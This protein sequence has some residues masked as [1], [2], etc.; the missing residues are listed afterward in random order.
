[1]AD[2]VRKLFIDA[3]ERQL[4]KTRRRSGIEFRCNIFRR[5]IE[6]RKHHQSAKQRFHVALIVI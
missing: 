1:M 2:V 4:G 5:E 3:S 6:S